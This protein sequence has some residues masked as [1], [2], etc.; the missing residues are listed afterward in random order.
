MARLAD[1]SVTRATV[2]L[3][4]LAGLLVGCS[5][6]MEMVVPEDLSGVSE[7]IPAT[8]R[9]RWSG[10]LADETFTLGPYKVTDVDRDWNISKSR[11]FAIPDFSVSSGKSE[12]GYAYRFETPAG[13]M[14]GECL[15][16][17]KDK[18]LGLKG[19][20]FESRVDKL[21]CVCM[22][23][24]TEVARVMVEADVTA[25][26]KGILTTSSQQYRVES[27]KEWKG[28]LSSGPAGYRVDGDQPVGAV[29]VLNPG[30]IWLARNLE[31][32]QRVSLA[33][34]FAGLMLY[35]PP[36]N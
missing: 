17:G 6:T 28:M 3:M 31:Q 11:W 8:D 33:C 30:R 20:D 10:A 1:K 12:G 26:Y 27:I 34:T 4:A 35:L 36:T 5:T 25:G 19:V 9:S 18:G 15:T 22:Q 29:E 13:R 21:S 7:V 16:A 32:P 2:V 24:E 23:G 14:S